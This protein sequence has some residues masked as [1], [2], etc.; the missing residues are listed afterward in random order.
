MTEDPQPLTLQQRIAA[1]NVA[2]ASN[3]SSEFASGSATLARPTSNKESF[4]QSTHKPLNGVS[5]HHN[6]LSGRDPNHSEP[7]SSTN[8]GLDRSRKTYELQKERQD[9]KAKPGPPPLPTRKSSQQTTSSNS[10]D[11]PANALGLSQSITRDAPSEKIAGS[12]SRPPPCL[13][14]RRAD[15]AISE[16]A[17]EKTTENGPSLPSP[18]QS[19]LV[20]KRP[21]ITEVSK[22]G[23][24]SPPPQLPPRR[25]TDLPLVPE[26]SQ[27][28]TSRPPPSV[29]SQ[30]A[31]QAPPPPN[32]AKRQLPP[33][34]ANYAPNSD[35]RNDSEHS[36]SRPHQAQPPPVPLASRPSLSAIQH[37]KT[38]PT[39]LR[40]DIYIERSDGSSQQA[41]CLICRDFTA[42]DHH[43]SLF[44]R[45][46]VR[47]LNELA[48]QLTS[49]FSSLTDK[50]RVIFTWLHHNIAYDAKL[51]YSDGPRATTPQA[52]LEKGLAV[53]SGYAD[54]FKLLATQAGLQCVVINGHGKGAGFKA[55]PAGSTNLPEYDSNHA[56]NAVRIDHGEWKLI[57]SC[58]GAGSIDPSIQ[59]FNKHFKPDEFTMSNE[60]FGKK[61]FPGEKDKFFLPGGRRLSWHEYM[62]FVRGNVSGEDLSVARSISSRS[63]LCARPPPDPPLLYSD[64]VP[65]YGIGEKTIIPST[66]FIPRSSSSSSSSSSSPHTDIVRFSFGLRCPHWDMER[67]T[68]LGPPPVFALIVQDTGNGKK[69]Y[70]PFKYIP[71]N[72]GGGGGERWQLDV[73]RS[74]LLT[75]SR[76]T[77][78]VPPTPVTAC[79]I[80]RFGERQDTRG[81]KVQDFQD[82]IGKVGFASST[83]IGWEI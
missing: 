20:S 36:F 11:R 13:P 28:R 4:P 52:T 48:Q 26:K 10:G 3:T 73:K 82:G 51:Y 18:S 25:Q 81:M 80:T 74:Q 47:S 6:F 66:K 76:D 39:M 32:S 50:A 43:A 49:P 24:I 38:D 67:H 40:S 70:V 17:V 63:T 2:H 53:C 60:D 22:T 59:Q 44:P 16:S 23:G 56:W 7:Q 5:L 58:W 69:G 71:G 30:G 61:H 1:L 37:P 78:S 65:H 41:S 9:V 46:R 45:Q 33:I 15:S 19:S 54:L 14:A 72:G 64:T 57:D 12:S 8:E 79:V 27:D 29:E 55:S 62:D 31:K 68:K 83:I 21:V 77:V 42:P 75:S 34:P 35:A